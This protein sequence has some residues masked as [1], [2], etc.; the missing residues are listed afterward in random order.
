MKLLDQLCQSSFVNY[1]VPNIGDFCVSV[2]IQ[3]K[4]SLI[5]MFKVFIF[6]SRFLDSHKEQE[7][8]AKSAI[9]FVYK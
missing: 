5:K 6:I 4:F 3:K 7:E 1:T 8:I 2:N 9:F